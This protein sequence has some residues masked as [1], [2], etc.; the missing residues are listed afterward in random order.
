MK[1]PSILLP[2]VLLQTLGFLVNAQVVI[3]EIHYHPIEEPAF[4]ADGTP[5][6][7]LTEDVHEFVEIHNP[8]ATAVDIGGWKLTDGVNFTFTA[9][10]S[11]PAGGFKVIARDVARIQTVY[12]IGGVLGPFIAGGRLSNTGD[13]LI[14]KNSA[15]AVVDSVSYSGG[16]PWAQS[17][18]GLGVG[19]DW[20]RINPLPYQYKGRSLQRV[21]FTA[22][23]D[24]PANWVAAPLAIGPTPGSRHASETALVTPRP[25]VIASSVAQTS[26][27]APIIRAS[28]SVLLGATFTS[29]A[30]LSAVEVQYFL[31]DINSYAETRFS[32]AM[33]ESPAGS[34]QYS[35]TIPGQADRS[36]VRYRIRA[37]RGAGL[38][39]VSPR[40]DDPAIVPTGASARE[41]WHAYFVT[42]VRASANPIYDAFIS[43][44]SLSVLSTN[45]NQ[46]PSRRA[47][48]DGYPRDADWVL[49]TDPQWNGIQPA[50]MIYNGTVHDIVMRHHG[51]RYRRDVNRKSYKWQFPRNNLLE[52]SIQGVFET[53]KS[54]DGGNAT[55]PHTEWAHLLHRTAGIP[56]SYTR[57]VDLYLNSDGLLT[58]LEQSEN[59]DR[60]LERY[61]DDRYKLDPTQPKLLPGEIYKAKGTDEGANAPYRNEAR[62]EQLSPRTA[63]A[64]ASP[65]GRTVLGGQ[66]T[67]LQQYS[68]N[69]TLQDHHWKGSKQFK[70]MIDALW[71]A[72]GQGT[73]QLK[74]YLNANWDV[75]RTLTYLALRNWG[76]PWDDHFHNYYVYRQANGKWMMMPWDF[77][78]EFSDKSA[79]TNI[80]S[81]SGNTFKNAFIVQAFN[82]EFKQKLFLLNNTL[83]HPDNLLS[84]GINWGTWQTDR[85]N[86]VNS[87]LALG[88]F[89]RPVKPIAI[90]PAGGSGVI[91]PASLSTSAY[92]HTSGGTTGAA[93]HTKTKWEIRSAT[94]TYIE[95]VYGAT[96]T[97]SLTS[98]PIPFADMELGGTYFWRVTHYDQLDH[99]S[100]TSDEATFLFGAGPVTQTLIAMDAT[101]LW[102][103][104]AQNITAAPS[105]WA[106]TTFNDSAWTQG[107]APLGTTTGTIPVAIR[108]SVASGTP[109]TKYFRV[110][111]NYAGT[112]G[113]TTILRLRLL[114]DDGVYVYLNG[115]EIKRAGIDV[116]TTDTYLVNA[117]RTV[118]D[119]AF[120]PGAGTWF[121]V[122]TTALVAGDNVIA[123]SLHQIDPA[124]A[125]LVFG[126]ELEATYTPT[127]GN[128]AINEVCADNRTVLANGGGYPDYVELINRGASALDI[129]GLTM[130]DDPLLPAKFTFPVGTTIA[131]GGYLIVWCDTD[132]A[133]P[134]LHTGFKLDSGG[135]SLAIYS[136]GGLV[137]YVTFG[138][139]APD[140]PIGRVPNGSGAFALI[141]PSPGMANVA[142]TLGSSASLRVNEWMANPSA[143][144]DWFELYNS[145]ANPVALSG[146]YLADDV[147]GPK[148]TRIP[149][150]SFIASKG[151]TKFVADSTTAGGNRCNFKLAA[152]G[153]AIV[154]TNT[155][156]TS[157]LNSVNFGSQT[158]GVSQGRLPDGGGSFAQFPQSASPGASNYL[159]APVVIS[160]AL[161]NSTAPLE[162][163]IELYNPTAS[164]VNIG[165]WWLSDDR[166]A[167]QKFQIT[168]GTT[169]PA[170][171][172]LVLYES[173]FN[174]GVNAFSLG[175]TGDEIVLS[176]TS[177]ATLTGYR[178]QVTFGAAADGVS[179]GRVSTTSAVPEFWP[180]LGRTL[181]GANA[182]PR[183][184][185][186]VI[187]EVM[188]HPQDL[189][190]AVD[191]VR[192]EFIELH[193]T[194]TSPQN[195]GGWKLKGDADFTFPAGTTI[196]PGD[197]VIVVSFDPAAD[198][199]SLAAFRSAYGIGASVATYGPFVLKLSNSSAAIELAYP[200]PVV[201]AA[202]PFILVDKIEYLDVAP[203]A[204]GADGTGLAL[205]RVSRTV[206]GNDPSNWIASN[207]TP[208]SV[209]NVQSAIV[210]SDGDGMP[211]TWENANGLNRFSAADANAD[212]DGDGQSNA[213]EYQAGTNP[214]SAASAFRSS[215]AKIAGGFRVQFTA[216]PGVA[217]SVMARDSLTAGSW[218]KIRDVAAQGTQHE[219]ITDDLTGQPQRYYQVVTPQ[220]P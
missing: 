192:D 178:S 67:A 19:E 7:D 150:L 215:V 161:T 105:V 173:Q 138:L 180:L 36:I 80:Y 28:Q 49:P 86:S 124:S 190:G 151:F 165:G 1:F 137:D 96:S 46:G 44:A 102:R 148:N 210:D 52:G 199:T 37:N 59:D 57:K 117:N 217:Y 166:T 4:A 126:L 91:P 147:N 33:A 72:K 185:P 139:Q 189:T 202:T 113:P 63:P 111:F 50:I 201:G 17:A 145:D 14:L 203:W 73:V 115:Q 75:D 23:S 99:P 157:L 79:T 183:T 16:F 196:L 71:T 194:T 98:L 3:S 155:N 143:G 204:T 104:R 218:V 70:D 32:V 134:G 193:N 200:G 184:G 101:T 130:T 107:A 213:R 197:Y 74:A 181:P 45:I 24:D 106:A 182:A 42:P 212:S 34:G 118:A 64:V 123:A 76:C 153:E 191:N 56:T 12:G 128:L 103:Y 38:E 112:T 135:Q 176:A 205:Q 55:A 127:G 47:T 95:P 48:A 162:D 159:T 43:T 125:D 69:Y 186:I 141:A 109:A 216:M 15:E 35:A 83:L 10:T 158:Q 58:R 195:I 40:A 82:A 61:Y 149:A 167:L 84:M 89:Q 133:A 13:T 31:D 41:A 172:Y 20:T 78:Y 6:L 208:G 26:D 54:A 156:G 220:Q 174:T 177:G 22:A 60:M 219:E 87:Q 25:I 144:D 5:T 92:S 77:D 136:A 206:I 100:V 209:N 85:F 2:C 68:Y 132:L 140:L 27:G 66:W 114:V 121:S 154:L 116:S 11:I 8:G 198:A 188:Y 39:A 152:G 175:S 169:I 21:S 179:F 122:P 90:S 94:G 214:Q 53:D 65:N 163:T 97:T 88:V 142:K 120:E 187:N 110:H 62:G 170:G 93:T 164:S 168:A 108:T 160:E 18:D 146:L 129:G 131:A 119:A 211:D 51:S 171:G 81:D 29:T 207:P 9:G 30:S